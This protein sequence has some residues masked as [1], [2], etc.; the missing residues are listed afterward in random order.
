MT[1][2]NMPKRRLTHAST[3]ELTFATTRQRDEEAFSKIIEDS[4][5]KVV[6]AMK[7]RE[8]PKQLYNCLGVIEYMRK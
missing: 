6:H 5:N 7:L 2:K 4:M 3:V 1:Q 8:R